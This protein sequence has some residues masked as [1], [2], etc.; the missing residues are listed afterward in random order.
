MSDITLYVHFIKGVMVGSEIVHEE[1]CDMLV[2][3]FLIVRLIF[4]FPK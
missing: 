3:D 4:E 1:D 2:F